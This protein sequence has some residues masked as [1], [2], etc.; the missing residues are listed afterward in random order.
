MR[1]ITILILG[2]TFCVQ[3]SC[4]NDNKIQNPNNN[5]TNEGADIITMA[6]PNGGK[7]KP[8]EEGLV[9]SALGQ[10]QID[11]NTFQLTVSGLVDSSFILTWED[12]QNWP[13]VYSDTMLMYCVEG[14]EVIGNWKGILVE[15]LLQRASVKDSGKFVLFHCV[16]GY[17]TALPISYLEKYKAMLAYQVNGERLKDRNGFP[18]RLVSFGKFGYKWAKWV[19][20]LEILS[21]SKIGYWEQYGYSDK[22]DVKLDRRKH[23]EGDNAQSLDY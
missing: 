1:I 14:W 18:L 21:E 19:N 23:Y 16:E 4:K 8:A 2:L 7:L 3:L 6:T 9:R 15:E 22:A 10:P 17:R 13:A 20:K 11:L 12:I 5:F